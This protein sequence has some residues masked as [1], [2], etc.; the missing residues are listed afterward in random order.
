MGHSRLVAFW[1]FG[2]PSGRRPSLA[3]FATRASRRSRPRCALYPAEERTTPSGSRGADSQGFFVSSCSASSSLASTSATCASPSVSCISP[4]ARRAS[5]EVIAFFANSAPSLRADIERESFSIG[6][7]YI[8][9]GYI[10]SPVVN[11]VLGV[12]G[13]VICKPW[14]ARNSNGFSKADFRLNM[15]DMTITCPAGQVEPIR[16]GVVV[17]FDPDE[18]DRCPLRDK[19]S[20]ARRRFRPHRDDCRR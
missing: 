16:P 7:L 20:M 8:D 11:D 17:E 3:G 18:C 4:K 13:D 9:R 15:R 10:S 12:G 6:E 14:V 19:C 1:P 5:A 2:R